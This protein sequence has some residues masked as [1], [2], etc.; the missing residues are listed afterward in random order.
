MQ[1]NKIQSKSQSKIYDKYIKNAQKINSLLFQKRFNEN[2]YK[3]L[4]QILDDFNLIVSNCK[5]YN[6]ESFRVKFVL[7]SLDNSASHDYFF[8]AAEIINQP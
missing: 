4:N 3:C 8:E 5:L 1:A 2:S 7:I 6:G